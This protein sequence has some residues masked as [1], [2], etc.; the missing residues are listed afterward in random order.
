LLNGKLAT[1][2]RFLPSRNSYDLQLADPFYVSDA[3]AL[4]CVG[5]AELTSVTQLRPGTTVSHLK[6]VPMKFV[7][8]AA[9]T[10]EPVHAVAEVS[11]AQ[12]AARNRHRLLPQPL[13]AAL[14]RLQQV[15]ISGQASATNGLLVRNVE[16]EFG[17][18]VGPHLK[19]D[20]FT[21]RL[22]SEAGKTW[23][24]STFD[25]CPVVT[26]QE[27]L[28]ELVQY[29]N[30]QQEAWQCIQDLPVGQ[31]V[32]ILD[33]DY[34]GHTG[35]IAHPYNPELQCYHV[36]LENFDEVAGG[37]AAMAEEYGVADLPGKSI[38]ELGAIWDRFGLRKPSPAT[39]D[40]YV[41]Q[42]MEFLPDTAEG[43]HTLIFPSSSLRPLISSPEEV[44][45]LRERHEASLMI[46]VR[47]STT[48]SIVESVHNTLWT[49]T[50]NV[51][52][53]STASR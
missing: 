46:S 3:T 22:E 7:Q 40:A 18:I 48:P 10:P 39:A 33:R 27:H 42:A 36:Q 2:C 50:S 19:G 21:V 43:P 44:F 23:R 32:E 25:L 9:D 1:T 16:D 29:S 6:N 12:R 53:W 51:P 34:L 11:S 30:A 15:Q 5:P 20:T 8:L 14:P 41:L 47:E 37:E 17:S 49:T 45:M 4:H 38:D 28:Q 31:A 24:V 52:S 13:W 35:I 26:S